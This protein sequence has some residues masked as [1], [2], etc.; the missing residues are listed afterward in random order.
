MTCAAGS[1]GCAGDGS[2][3]FDT[4]VLIWHF[5]GYREAAELIESSPDRAVSVVTYMELLRGA[6]S[7]REI[8]VIR[9]FFPGHAIRTLPISETI[10]HAAATLMEEHALAHGL[11]LADALIGATARQARAPLATGNA[12]HFRVIPGLEVKP[13][14]PRGA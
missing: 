1:V 3:I 13:F 9:R 14:R 12:R 8:D 5:R 7:R 10:S 6:R 4:D 11:R 2:L